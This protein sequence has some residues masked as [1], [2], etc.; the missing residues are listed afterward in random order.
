MFKKGIV[1]AGTHKLGGKDVKKL[2]QLM[3]KSFPH[4]SDEEK[5][6]LI[7][8]KTEVTQVKLSN[9]AVAYSLATEQNGEA[10]LFFDISGHGDLLFPTVYAFSIV[11]NI[12]P[13][14][15][16]H[17]E[18]SGKVLQGAD[19]FLQGVL[20]PKGGF[21]PPFLAGSVRALKVPG[22]PIPF[23]VGKMAVS[24]QEAERDGMKGRG[25][26]VFHCYGDL[27]W[28]IGNKISPNE[29]FTQKCISPV[30]VRET[31]AHDQGDSVSKGEEGIEDTLDQ[32]SRIN[33]EGTLQNGA[34][35]E[36]SNEEATCLQDSNLE[37][38]N[39]EVSLD[40]LVEKAAIGGFKSL[41]NSELPILT[42]D[43]YTRHMQPLKPSGVTFDFKQTKYKK[44]SKLLDKFAKEKLI[45]LKTIRKQEHIAKVNKEAEEILT[46]IEMPKISLKKNHSKESALDTGDVDEN[47]NK[48]NGSKIDFAVELLYKPPSSLRDI[49]GNDSIDIKDK[50]YT[51]EEV[52]NYVWKYCARISDVPDSESVMSA[53]QFHQNTD[54]M[55]DQLLASSLWGKKEGI[56]EG[57]VVSYRILLDRFLN[58]LQVWHKLIRGNV[59]VTRRGIPKPISI[60][61][62]KRHGRSI[63]AV[64]RV[65]GKHNF[66]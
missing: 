33:L 10:P 48:D 17:S 54:V 64:S 57:S 38:P 11:P 25:L 60:I 6:S 7:P 5:N 52:D 28:D 63:T 44:L 56:Q 51:R 9:R 26:M 37:D 35:S 13:S 8:L 31:I 14:I 22:N 45:T 49:F 32:I 3:E 65:E 41:K 53:S 29:G 34:N 1:V 46:W 30:S 12:V 61:A 47:T 50:L 43:F 4:L 2:R 15:Y 58:K 16:T 59:E 62:E 55:V 20:V 40:V 42:S 18:V 36:P 21:E 24:L 23:A 19:L 66:G 39:K 27:L